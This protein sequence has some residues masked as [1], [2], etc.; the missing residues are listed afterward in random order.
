MA[1]T[2]RFRFGGHLAALHQRRQMSERDVIDQYRSWLTQQFDADV[3]ALSE[4]YHR[5]PSEDLAGLFGSGLFGS[6]LSGSA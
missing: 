6:G 3:S 2:R 5:H 4:L 1:L